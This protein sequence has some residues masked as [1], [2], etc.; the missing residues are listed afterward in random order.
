MAVAA[1]TSTA[2]SRLFDTHAIAMSVM[3]PIKRIPKI[4]ERV[5]F[6]KELRI[7]ASLSSSTGKLQLPFAPGVIPA[8][9]GADPMKQIGHANLGTCLPVLSEL[10]AGITL[11]RESYLRRLTKKSQAARTDDVSSVIASGS[12]ALRRQDMKIHRKN[13]NGHQ[14]CTVSSDN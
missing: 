8:W 3:A 5:F 14:P 9:E 13:P 1:D 2:G 6:Q 10:K 11:S 7:S 4:T 12:P